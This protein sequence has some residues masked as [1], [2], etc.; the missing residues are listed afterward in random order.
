MGEAGPWG[1]GEGGRGRGRGEENP[2][3]GIGS[4]IA[5]VRGWAR[6]SGRC[7]CC[8]GQGERVVFTQGLVCGA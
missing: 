1:D 3:G 4:L 2:P 6:R 7:C 5:G 8:G